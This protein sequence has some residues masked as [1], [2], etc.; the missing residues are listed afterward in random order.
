M[1]FPD[2]LFSSFGLKAAVNAALE[3]S[4]VEMSLITKSPEK[5]K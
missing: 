3:K 4:G 2:V 1:Q 5:K